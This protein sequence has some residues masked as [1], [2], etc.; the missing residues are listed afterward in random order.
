MPRSELRRRA[1]EVLDPAGWQTLYSARMLRSSR[2]ANGLLVR[3]W[4]HR[5]ALYPAATR[6][7]RLA[8]GWLG[9]WRECGLPRYDCRAGC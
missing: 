5:W 7:W 8:V 2:G 3:A 6:E 4:P 1:A 9:G